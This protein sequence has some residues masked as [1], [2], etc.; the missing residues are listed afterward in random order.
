MFFGSTAHMGA[1]HGFW[2][3]LAARA[4]GSWFRATW[5]PYWDL[6]IPFEWTYPP[7]VPALAAAI[8][9]LRGVPMAVGFHSVTGVFYILGPLTLFVMAW[10]LTR[11]T[12]SSF[13]AALAY[14]LTSVTQLLA[15]DTEF[16]LHR[17]WDARRWYTVAIWDDTP[18]IAAL[19]FLPLVILFL[20]RS[21]ETRR[22]GY[23]AGAALCIA[24]AALGQRVRPGDGGAVGGLPRLRAAA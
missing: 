23:Y 14:S 15:P 10:R 21:I 12:A 16:A 6:G 18:P 5:W 22:P 19:A 20:A 24:G 13:L 7:L 17:I 1:M 2:T 3:A 11:A 4:G 8:S 9:S